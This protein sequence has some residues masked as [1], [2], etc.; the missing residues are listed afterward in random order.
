MKI[1]IYY[2]RHG[3]NRL[4]GGDI[5]RKRVGV[6]EFSTRFFDCT[7]KKTWAWSAFFPGLS[8]K[9]WWP[10]N[11]K[12]SVQNILDRL[13]FSRMG[14]YWAEATTDWQVLSRIM[15]LPTFPFFG[16]P[17]LGEEY[18]NKLAPPLPA[19]LVVLGSNPT[20]GTKHMIRVQKLCENSTVEGESGVS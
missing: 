8:R 6:C 1:K 15:D 2:Q 14:Q 18:T 5:D 4:D 11:K 19:L 7:K 17:I 3:V 9:M 10:S 20:S 12:L 13:L 16:N